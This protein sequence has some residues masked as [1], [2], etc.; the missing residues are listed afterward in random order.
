VRTQPNAV[1]ASLR[2]SHR[3]D[4]IIISVAVL[5]PYFDLGTSHVVM[6]RSGGKLS[7][8]STKTTPTSGVVVNAPCV[9]PHLARAESDK[10]QDLIADFP[11]LLDPSHLSDPSAGEDDAPITGEDDGEDDAPIADEDDGEDNAPIADED[12]GEDDFPIA[13]KDDGEDDPP[14]AGEDDGED[15]PPIAGK[16]DGNDKGI[17]P[18][19]LF[20][21]SIE[22]V[23]GLEGDAV[24]HMNAFYGMLKDKLHAKDQTTI[25]LSKDDYDPRLQFGLYLVKGGDCRSSAMAGNTSAYKWARKYHVVT[26]GQD[27]AVLVLWPSKKMGA[28]DVT[29]MR[30]ENL[31]QPT[32]IER[33]LA[34]LLKIHQVNHCKGNSLFVHASDRRSSWQYYTRGV[35]D[36]HGC[37]ST[38]CEA[39]ELQE[40]CCWGKEHCD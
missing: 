6:S 12:N 38:L 3:Q 8:R 35:Q 36:V 15:D 30:L 32:Y 14:I 4:N 18:V 37:L 23:E 7:R 39:F 5:V 28:V 24:R 29:A 17:T 40:A 16:D 26:A 1:V 33:V 20:D 21:W 11:A 2:C 19:D 27:S 22:G 9:V 31:Q 25:L 13:G 10:P 34:D